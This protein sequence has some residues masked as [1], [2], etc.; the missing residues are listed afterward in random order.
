M[1]RS[2]AV[3]QAEG[4]LEQIAET[5]LDDDYYVVRSGP[6]GAARGFNTVLTASVLAVFALLVTIAAVQT[7][8]DRPATER[9]RATLVADVAARKELL[10]T[11]EATA[12]RLQAE[13][14]ELTAV[15]NR[16]DPQLEALRVQTADR[17]A[18]GPGIRVAITPGEGASGL[19]RITD[20]DLRAV[21]NSLWY[22]GAEAVAVNGQRIGTL[23]SIRTTGAGI[24]VN[25]VPIGPPYTLVALGDQDALEDRFEDNPVRRRLEERGEAAGLELSVAPSSE[26][27]VEKAPADRLAISH[28]TAIE[29]ER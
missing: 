20:D 19:G 13:V 10:A 3:S 26:L 2:D 4:L 8:N 12:D 11:R 18:R 24:L 7:R 27:D 22:A 14:E 29:G 21:V 25:Y 6:D 16:L 15:A 5:A 28:A 23:S 1:A 9:E 17:A